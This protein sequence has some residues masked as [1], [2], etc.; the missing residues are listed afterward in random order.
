MKN[1]SLVTLFTLISFISFSQ[2][3]TKSG[4]ISIGLNFSGVP[5]TTISGADTSYINALSVSPSIGLRSKSGWGVAYSPS[6]VTS[7]NRPGVYMHNL[8]AGYERY[9]GKS[10]D[11]DF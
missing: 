5:I 3:S 8:T 9:G 6:F 7:G 11:L 2:D 1:Y 4:G 10:F